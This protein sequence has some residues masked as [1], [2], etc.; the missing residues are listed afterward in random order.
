[1]F[2]LVRT[3]KNARPKA[4]QNR[5]FEDIEAEKKQKRQPVK[6]GKVNLGIRGVL[7]YPL[8]AVVLISVLAM[9]NGYQS[10]MVL[11]EIAVNIQAGEDGAFLNEDRVIDY[12][13]VEQERML[14]GQPMNQIGLQDLETEL[15]ANPFVRDAQVYK[16]M[17]GVLHVDLNLRKPVARL[18]NDSGNYLYLD[19]EG[20][21]FP[22]SDLAAPHVVLVRG[23]FE[24]AV[25]DTFDCGIVKMAVPLIQYI[26]QDP[27]WNAFISEVQIS[28]N[29][30]I[31]LFPQI[32]KTYVKFGL[33]ED[34]EG[35]FDRIKT[36]YREWMAVKGWNAFKFISV[37]F[38]GQ[39][40]ATKR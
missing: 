26:N 37:E 11:E 31:T 20:V 36:F 17:S 15:L 5:R 10:A 24:E 33:P 12:L 7:L 16:S 40:V 32:G 14:I 18:L 35:K 22:S 25:A 13:T 39:V 9:V 30:H 21:K 19:E 28:P 38:D 3:Y 4:R 29:G 23:N 8:I 6:L 2:L 1:M 34:L 27:F